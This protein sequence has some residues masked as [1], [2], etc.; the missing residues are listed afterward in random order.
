MS[1]LAVIRIP[2]VEMALTDTVAALDGCY[3][4]VEETAFTENNLTL[5]VW[6]ACEDCSGIAAALRA[7]PSVR[8]SRLVDER[9]DER[10]YAVDLADDTLMPRDI[11][12]RFDGTVCEAY[13]NDSEWVVEVRFPARE[14][15]SAVADL[16]DE[17]GIEV[18]YESITELQNADASRVT[19]L[20][21]P[22]REAIQAAIDRGYYEIPRGV[23]LDTLSEELGVSHQALSERLRRAQEKLAKKRLSRETSQ[24]TEQV[25]D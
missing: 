2:P 6:I 5:H 20:T 9:E 1:T 10:L 8:E 16:F 12:Q 13:G 7:D 3:F 17:Y 22:Q 19:E 25:T 14:D 18:T 4:H 24:S 11:I 15:L 23:T 21:R